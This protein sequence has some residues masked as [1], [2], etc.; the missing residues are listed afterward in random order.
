MR[1]KYNRIE[2]AERDM[3][4]ILLPKTEEYNYCVLARTISKG[5][6]SIVPITHL[7]NDTN[8]NPR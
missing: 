3:E 5:R 1:T 6:E 2:V 4:I 8:P 7:T